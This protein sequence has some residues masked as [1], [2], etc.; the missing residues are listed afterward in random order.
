MQFEDAFNYLKKESCGLKQLKMVIDWLTA[1]KK[2]TDIVL[3]LV[4]ILIDMSQHF[5]YTLSPSANKSQSG[6]NIQ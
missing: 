3:L 6:S 1:A 4:E 2:K 5:I